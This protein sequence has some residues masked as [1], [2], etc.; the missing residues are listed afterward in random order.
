MVIK[1]KN[2]DIY[3]LDGPNPLMANQKIFGDFILHNK[4]GQIVLMPVEKAIVQEVKEDEAVKVLNEPKL[5]IKEPSKV[6]MWCL[7]AHDQEYIDKLYNEVYKRRVY[8]S[9]FLVEAIMVED[10]DIGM[11]FYVNTKS[12][13]EESIVYPRNSHKRWWRVKTIKPDQEGFLVSAVITD[14]HPDF[15][16]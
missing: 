2:G 5:S 7:P 14:Y 13:T 15:S 16:E 3:K 6:M 8:G 12:I 10:S 1:T 9:K 4:V 11:L